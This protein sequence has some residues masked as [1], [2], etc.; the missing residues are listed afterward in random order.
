MTGAEKDGKK[1]GEK[2]RRKRGDVPR[3]RAR[4]AFQK[5][6]VGVG[7]EIPS[8]SPFE[9]VEKRKEGERGDRGGSGFLDQ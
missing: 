9:R 8:S 6:G 1:E 5:E 2:E 7:G 4:G 3:A